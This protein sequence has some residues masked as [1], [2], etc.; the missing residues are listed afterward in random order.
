ML[1]GHN[2]M[3]SWEMLSKNIFCLFCFDNGYSKRLPD[4][5]ISVSKVKILQA[6]PM[7]PI[8]PNLPIRLKINVNKKS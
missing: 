2:I 3:L 8:C 5:L 7:D 1:V 6:V 4:F